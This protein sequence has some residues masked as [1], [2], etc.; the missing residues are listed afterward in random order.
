MR[1]FYSSLKYEWY[2]N[3]CE[4]TELINEMTHKE[5]GAA[6]LAPNSLSLLEKANLAIWGI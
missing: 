1:G 3:V 2:C 5:Y 6:L 4:S